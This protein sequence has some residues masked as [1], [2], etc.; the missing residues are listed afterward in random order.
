[1]MSGWKRAK[2]KTGLGKTCDHSILSILIIID[3]YHNVI[4]DDA[5]MFEDSPV[6]DGALKKPLYPRSESRNR[7]RRFITHF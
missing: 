1:M 6:N 2:I 5:A 3:I 4:F 7:C